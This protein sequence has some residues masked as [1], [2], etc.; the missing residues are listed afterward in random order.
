MSFSLIVVLPQGKK[1]EYILRKTI[2]SSKLNQQ[3]QNEINFANLS[4][5]EKPCEQS[6]YSTENQTDIKTHVKSNPEESSNKFHDV[7]II[8]SEI[9]EIYPS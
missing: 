8:E 5:V 2:Q 6:D 9:Y 7:I 3:N 1:I 4:I